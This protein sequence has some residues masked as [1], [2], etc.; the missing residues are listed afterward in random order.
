[1]IYGEELE[2][3]L[4]RIKQCEEF[5]DCDEIWNP[6]TAQLYLGHNQFVVFQQKLF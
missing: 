2:P 6:D 5:S 3:Y 1:M 4:E